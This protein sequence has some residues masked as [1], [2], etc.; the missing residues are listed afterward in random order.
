[1]V[2]YTRVMILKKCTIDQQN[3]E[4]VYDDL[5]FKIKT[6]YEQ[7]INLLVKYKCRIG[8]NCFFFKKY[9]TIANLKI[10]KE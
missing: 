9:L 7:V 10:I 8:M 4:P 6:H 2:H 1:M 3:N 5:N